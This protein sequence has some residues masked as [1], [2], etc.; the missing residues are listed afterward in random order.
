[1]NPVR[2]AHILPWSSIG[3][4]E[5][6]TMRLAEAAAESGFENLL[7]C[8]LDSERLRCTFQKHGLTTCC[9]RQVEPSYHK[10]IPYLR[11][12]RQLAHSLRRHHVRI[13]HCSDILAAHYAAL[14]GRLAGAY[15]LSHVRCQHSAI[16]ARDR[17]FLLPV[18]K[19]VF[20]SRDT[21]HTFGMEVP[22][23]RG[24]ILYDGFSEAH[25]EQ[26]ET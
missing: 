5:L 16:S 2:I 10:P 20:V 21:W 23:S 25:S 8:P 22:T 19:F 18:N 7:Y 11:A 15:V 4:T 24:Q 1:M 17:T 14:A 26:S 9:Y 13:V 3:G 12:A 6:A